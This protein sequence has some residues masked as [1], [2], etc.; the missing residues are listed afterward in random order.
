MT[1]QYAP[2]AAGD[3]YGATRPFTLAINNRQTVRLTAVD[4]DHLQATINA[5]RIAAQLKDN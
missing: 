4:L 2:A 3:R 1:M 5:A